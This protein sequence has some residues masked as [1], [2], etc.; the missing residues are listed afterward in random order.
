M[1]RSRN[2]C[3]VTSISFTR[4]HCVKSEAFQNAG[5]GW[6]ILDEGTILAD[7]DRQAQ[8]ARTVEQLAAKL[9]L[10]KQPKTE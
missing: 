7:P 10:A 2:W 3:G 5:D 6:R 9:A 4:R 8:V 1:M